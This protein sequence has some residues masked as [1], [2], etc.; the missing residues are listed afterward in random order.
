MA[1]STRPPRRQPQYYLRQLKRRGF[2]LSYYN[3]HC[4]IVRC[5]QCKAVVVNWVATHEAGCPNANKEVKHE[6]D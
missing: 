5:S 2:D 4:W 6:P 1:K 3:G